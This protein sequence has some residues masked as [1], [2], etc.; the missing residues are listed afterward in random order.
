MEMGL[1]YEAPRATGLHI[2]GIT[3]VF[4]NKSTGLD[5]AMG[6]MSKSRSTLGS[7][8]P[9]IP[10]P[11][12]T[13]GGGLTSGLAGA[14]AGA[15]VGGALAGAGTAAATGAAAGSIAPGVGTAIGAIVGLAGY[16]LS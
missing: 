10:Q 5:K 7:T 6:L 16:Y 13:I 2:P 15:A 4:E 1:N 11:G 8:Q 14:G 12:K 3:P 9:N